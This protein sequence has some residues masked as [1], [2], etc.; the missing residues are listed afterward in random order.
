MDA[1]LRLGV[2]RV[3][4]FNLLFSMMRN[5]TSI[6]SRESLP[7]VA[8]LPISNTFVDVFAITVDNKVNDMCTVQ[9]GN[10]I[11]SICATSLCKSTFNYRSTLLTIEQ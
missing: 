3:S 2:S 1:M 7:S 5:R 11:R 6:S 4:F 10:E 8:S 9:H